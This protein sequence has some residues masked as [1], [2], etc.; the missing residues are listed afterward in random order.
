MADTL[1]A[2]EGDTRTP[3]RHH[4][5]SLRPPQRHGAGQPGAG[6]IEPSP[7]ATMNAMVIPE[8]SKRLLAEFVGTF[9]LVFGGCGSAMFA[10]GYLSTPTLGSGAPVHLGIGF[11]GVALAF[12]L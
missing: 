8:M 10:A 6:P 9:W 4:L 5:P 7:Y 2:A 3:H 1:T 12:G 11:T